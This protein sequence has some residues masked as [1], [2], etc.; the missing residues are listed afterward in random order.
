[1]A[2][3]SAVWSAEPS[4]VPADTLTD[5]QTALTTALHDSTGSGSGSIDW[6]FALPDKD[7]DFLSPGETLTTSYDVTINDGSTSS[8]QTVTVTA[9]GAA[10]P[11]IVHP[12]TATAADTPF[13]DTGNFIAFGNLI[14]DAGDTDP[15]AS[16]APSIADVNGDPS[17]VGG[18]P[19]AG[20]YGDLFVFGDGTYLYQ[21]NANVDPLQVGDVV[22]DHF[23]FTVVDN[24][25]HSQATTLTMNVVGTDDFP[26]ITGGN[27]FGSV[28]EDAGPA[29]GVN[30]GFETGDLTGWIASPGV[31][32]TE[33]F[34]GGQFG[35]FAANL[36]GTGFL[37]QNVA[38]TPGQHYTLSFYVDGDPEAST[39]S[40]SAFWDGVQIFSQNDVSLGFHQYTFDLVGDGSHPT[41]QLQFDYSGD[42]PGLLVDAVSI[43]PDTSPP[44]ETTSGN[45]TFSDVETGDTHT[46]SFTPVADGYFGTFSL[47]PVSESGGSGSV[48]WH[49]T[50]DNA[51][52]Q[53]LAQGQVVLQDYLVSVT[54]DHGLST[55]QD[56]TVA[57]NG[58][59][60]APTAVSENIVTDAGASGTIDIPTW[61]LAANDTDP[62][63]TDHVSVNSIQSSSGGTAV[64]FGDVFFVDDATPGGSF[65]YNS[66]DGIAVSANTATAT[67]GINNAVLHL[68]HRR[69]RRQ[70]PDRHQRRRDHDRRHRQR[71]LLRQFRQ[72]CHDRRR[73][74]R[75]LRVHAHQRRAG[76]H[77]R[78]QQHHRA[79]SYRGLRRGFR[80]R[81]DRRH[82]RVVDLR[83]LR[84]QPVLG[85]WLGSISIPPTRRFTSAPTGPRHQ[86]RR[87]RRCSRRQ[88]SMRTIS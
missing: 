86:R 49:F 50:V 34:I 36:A 44:T 47:D 84:R 82:G 81:A 25:G 42:G 27:P 58:A 18:T 80:R 12:V 3:D 20:T 63:A 83:D 41:T 33:T 10:D 9:T 88:P 39:T 79:G 62:D 59:N 85:V 76:H 56:V 75:H 30:G 61:A 65:T 70:H 68:A 40:F 64:P 23:N 15:D 77:H 45:V 37:E 13:P 43:T 24:E 54:D 46:A 8:T 72:P 28:T 31:S 7:L 6:T 67:V 73:R 2:F 21:A 26:A 55:L 87:W 16:I 51:D 11:L 22:T 19:I 66:T 14:T 5:L 78:L 48:N 69:R 53:S 29:A 57:L 52:I 74:Q 17:N 1:M 35:N 38:T 71:H 4:F 60:D 32:V